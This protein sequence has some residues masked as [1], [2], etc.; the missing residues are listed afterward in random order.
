MKSYKEIYE[1][2]YTDKSSTATEEHQRGKGTGDIVVSSLW[3]TMAVVS[4]FIGS[5]VFTL[6]G[7]VGGLYFLIR[8][9]TKKEIMTHT[10]GPKD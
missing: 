5:F 9:L 1:T 4:G 10:R 8:G 7:I 3:F 6:L 2:F